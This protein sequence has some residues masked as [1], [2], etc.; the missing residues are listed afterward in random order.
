MSV[1]SM[2]HKPLPPTHS[3][4]QPWS[5]KLLKE[6]PDLKRL[7][8]VYGINQLNAACAITAARKAGGQQ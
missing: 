6:S 7:I 2:K 8:A 1:E 5:W 3:S 4:G